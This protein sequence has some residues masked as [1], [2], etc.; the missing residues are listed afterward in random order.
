MTLN[1]VIKRL[2]SLSLSHKQLNYFFIGAADEFLDSEV[3]YPACFI[4]L[5]DGN[6]S[7]TERQTV[8]NFEVFLFDLLDTASNSLRNEWEIKS[9]MVSIAQD[10]IA[11]MYDESYTDWDLNKDFNFQIKDY[12]FNDVTAGVSFKISIGVRFDANKCQV[13]NE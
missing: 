8:Y 1:Q 6:F 2:E 12:Q 9:D 7:I 13:P 10:L 4:E 11:L 3:T 5:K